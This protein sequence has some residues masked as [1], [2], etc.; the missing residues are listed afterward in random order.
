MVAQ[1]WDGRKLISS[2]YFEPDEQG[3]DLFSAYL[4]SLK[5]EPVSLLLDLIEEEFRQVTIPLLGRMDRAGIIQRNFTKFFRTSNYRYA[6]SQSIQKKTRK[7]E[8]LL[9]TGLTNQ[10]LIKPW[11][12]IIRET[13]TPLSGILSLP[14]ISEAL[15]P[16]FKAQQDCVIMVSQQVPSNL[17]Q[18]VFLKGKLI[19]SRLVPIASF[20]QGN[21]AADLIRDIESSKRYLVSQRIIDRNDV[22]SV[23]ILCNKRHYEKLSLKCKDD[24]IFEY[25]IHNINEL[26]KHEKIEVPNEQDF[27]SALFCYYAVKKRFA[28]HYARNTEKR[29]F[30][31]YLAQLGSKVAAIGLLAVSIGLSGVSVA[32]GVLYDA[33]IT[34]MGLLEQKYQSKF[35]HLNEQR[36]DS[37]IS[38]SNLKNV[39]KTVERIKQVYQNTPHE[40]MSM[41][42]QDIALFNDM[43]VRQLEW[44]VAST[45]TATGP[46]TQPVVKAK[47]VVRRSR[48]RGRTAVSKNFY[49]IMNV[50]GELLNFD[51]DYRYALSLINDIEDAMKVSSKY[52]IVEITKRPLNIESN[53]KISGDVSNKVNTR[54]TS[55]KKADFAFR[56]VR[57]VNLSEK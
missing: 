17:R 53:E 39:V 27:S 37:D 56:V 16:S 13:R 36:V 23:Q 34:E 7:E 49:E 20:Y 22:I 18:S 28:N 14:L 35:N 44:F 55:F 31:H 33:S 42:S 46:D 21:Y 8:R 57:E 38:T 50:S 54:N 30:Y 15:V 43:R 4:I 10:D 12:E 48:N 41:V 6:A 9:L 3:M 2:V 1:E 47:K 52:S 24:G 29:Y 5:N 11:L 32:R 19:L 51:G 25:G 45:P 40:M 26:I